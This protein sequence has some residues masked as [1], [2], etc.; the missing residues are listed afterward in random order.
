MTCLT[1]K[2]DKKMNITTDFFFD[3]SVLQIYTEI[4]SDYLPDFLKEFEYT[5]WVWSLIGSGIIGLSGI[6]P[7]LI[8]PSAHIN[9]KQD[10]TSSSKEIE[11]RKY[12]YYYWW[13]FVIIVIFNLNCILNS[14]QIGN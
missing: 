12:I 3:S 7:L 2:L 14:K 9:N 13:I 5:P 6:L 8:I 10:K 4:L 1:V 11:D